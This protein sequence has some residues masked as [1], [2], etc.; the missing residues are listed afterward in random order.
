MVA[1]LAAGFFIWDLLFCCICH[2]GA[3]FAAHATCAMFIY[4]SALQPFQNRAACEFLVFEISTPLLNLRQQLLACK[5]TD[6]R[7]FR[8]ASLGFA[9]LFLLCRWVVGLPCSVLWWADCLRQLRD[10]GD[11]PRFKPHV[12]G[13]SVAANVFLNGLNIYWGRLVIKASRRTLAPKPSDAKK[14]D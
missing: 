9:F 2:Q 11:D 4:V 13:A 3:A 6:T 14:V 5:R 8:L 1:R 10:H 12:L 7:L